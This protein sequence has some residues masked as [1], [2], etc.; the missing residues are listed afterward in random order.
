MRLNNMKR[1]YYFLKNGVLRRKE[2]TMYFINKDGKRPVPIEKIRAIY[3]YGR[4]SFTSGVVSLLAKNGVC[5]HFYDY[6]GL[7]E[8]SFYPR[9]SLLS[10]NL[11]VKQVEHYLDRDK[12]LYLAEKFVEGATKNILKNLKY[13]KLDT[14]EM[15]LLLEEIEKQ[16]TITHLMNIEGRIRELYYTRLDEILPQGFKIQRRERRPPTNMINAMISFG[17]Q[18]LYGDVVTEIYN[19]QL[20]PTISYLHEPFERRF[21]LALDIIEIFKPVIVDRIIFKLVNKRIFDESCFMKELNC[22]LMN[23]K[24]RRKFIEEY[25]QKMGTTIKHKGLRRNVSYRQL[26]RLELYKLIK[27]LLGMSKYKP[28]VIWW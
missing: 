9:E 21:S 3:A 11:L 13:Y 17:N 28:F 14:M 16:N 12:R 24:G 23:D 20:N 5:I 7:Y 22:V 2:N 15:E 27:H 6:Y 25:E 19:T 1:N 26:I 4:I 10:G 8:G 18:L